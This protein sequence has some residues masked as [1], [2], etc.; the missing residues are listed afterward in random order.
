MIDWYAKINATSSVASVK[1]RGDF[2]N[3]GAGAVSLIQTPDGKF[4]W[5]KGTDATFVRPPQQGDKQWCDDP[6]TSSL[7]ETLILVHPPKINRLSEIAQKTAIS[8][9]LY[10][11]PQVFMMIGCMHHRTKSSLT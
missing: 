9:C 3:G 11:G 4:W 1:L 2:T 5:F 10:F 6:A 7:S 8:R